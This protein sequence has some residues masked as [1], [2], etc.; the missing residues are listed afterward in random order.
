VEP[1]DFCNVGFTDMENS[2]RLE[3]NPQLNPGVLIA[4]F[5]GWGN[6]LD[7][8]NGMAV[9]LIRKLKA[10][11]FAS[12][13]PDAFYRFDEA[14]PEVV[15]EDGRLKTLTT[16]EGVFFAAKN[17]FGENDLVILKAREPH[18]GWFGFVKGL[19]ALCQDLGIHTVVTLGSMFDAVLHTDRTVSGITT[20]DADRD[21]LKALKVSPIHYS[22][23]SAIHSLIHTEAPKHAV[24]SVSLW[25]H[26]PYYLQN[27]VHTGLIAHL[28]RILAEFVGFQLDTGEL[29]VDWERLSKNIQKLI[30][31]NPKLQHL[32]DTLRKEKVKGSWENVKAQLKSGDNVI[33]LSD[34]FDK[35]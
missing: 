12:V 13:N 19:Y 3:E 15:I 31:E 5:E 8:S 9:Y 27:T 10:R 14:R 18:M 33:N 28:G 4:G 22:G 20:R 35:R 7:V 11:R 25:C 24:N 1:S 34:F 30:D 2:I 23:P 21:R 32:I 16:V 26:C 17:D 29:E 6:A